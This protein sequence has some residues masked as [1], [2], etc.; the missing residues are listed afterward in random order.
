[1]VQEKGPLWCGGGDQLHGHERSHMLLRNNNNKTAAA[2]TT[3]TFYSHYTGHLVLAFI[4][5]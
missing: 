3:T 1:V 2:A 4:P 5:S